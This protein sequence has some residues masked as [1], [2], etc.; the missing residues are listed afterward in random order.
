MAAIMSARLLFGRSWR[1][2]IASVPRWPVPVQLP[3]DVVEPLLHGASVDGQVG[4][5]G[6]ERAQD[7]LE[8]GKDLLVDAGS[9]PLGFLGHHARPPAEY[10]A[11]ILSLSSSR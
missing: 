9:V 4:L 11:R 1:A 7:L 2:L 10:L 8:R 5:D 6:P 3:Q